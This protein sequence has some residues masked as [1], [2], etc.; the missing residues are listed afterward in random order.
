MIKKTKDIIKLSIII[1]LAVLTF[2]V[3]Y[4]VGISSSVKLQKEYE[5][6]DITDLDKVKAIAAEEAQSSSVRPTPVAAAESSK[7]KVIKY[8]SIVGI[9]ILAIAMLAIL[10]NKEDL[11]E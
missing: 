2:N 7:S 1:L 11:D 5:Q 10:S 9:L 8:V 6:R 4:D 3:V